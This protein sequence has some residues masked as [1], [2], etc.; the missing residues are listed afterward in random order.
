MLVNSDEYESYDQEMFDEMLDYTEGM[1][2]VNGFCTCHPPYKGVVW[3][4]VMALPESKV[5]PLAKN[6][7]IE[8]LEDFQE[9]IEEERR[10]N[11]MRGRVQMDVR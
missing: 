7:C 1:K 4:Q 8:T 10:D 6:R 2:E 3:S 5:K 9:E 11:A